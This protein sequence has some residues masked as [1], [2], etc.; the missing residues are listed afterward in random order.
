MRSAPKHWVLLRDVPALM[1]ALMA[2]HHHAI[3]TTY[4]DPNA[5]ET[6]F[7]ARCETCNGISRRRPAYRDHRFFVQDLLRVK[8][9]RG[10]SA[11][12]VWATLVAVHCPRLLERRP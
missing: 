9:T 4:A 1:N 6:R 7:R 8:H 10:C 5:V 2:S 11:G 12:L 3:G